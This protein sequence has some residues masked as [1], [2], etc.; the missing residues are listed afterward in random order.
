MLGFLCVT[1]GALICVTKNACSVKVSVCYIA[2]MVL[3]DEGHYRNDSNNSD[4]PNTPLF[5]EKLFNYCIPSIRTPTFQIIILI[6]E[7][8]HLAELE[9]GRRTSNSIQ[10]FF[11]ASVE[12]LNVFQHTTGVFKRLLDY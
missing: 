5:Q 12:L 7:H 9:R 2:T 6:S 4:H 11:G 1:L 8:L 3:F 10:S